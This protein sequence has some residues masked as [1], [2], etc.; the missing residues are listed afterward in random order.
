MRLEN[1]KI[2]IMYFIK[3]QT[4]LSENIKELS[5]KAVFINKSLGDKRNNVVINGK[6]IYETEVFEGILFKE[7]KLPH[8]IFFFLKSLKKNPVLNDYENNF[9]EE[10]NKCPYNFE[11]LDSYEYPFIIID[12][13]NE[14]DNFRIVNNTNFDTKILEFSNKYIQEY[15]NRCNKTDKM[16]KRKKI[17]G[18]RYD[19]KDESE[20]PHIHFQNKNKS[21]EFALNLIDIYFENNNIW[22]H[23]YKVRNIDVPKNIIEELNQRFKLPGDK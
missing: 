1:I 12:F 15:L 11:V 3:I 14:T 13:G 23:D 19:K 10:L 4:L 17:K 6:N 7:A 18:Y 16:L 21:L 2:N 20:F 5:E 9:H 8:N 22:K